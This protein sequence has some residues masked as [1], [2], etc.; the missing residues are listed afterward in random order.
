MGKIRRHYVFSGYVQGVGFRYA[1]SHTAQHLGV[2]GWVRN[3]YDGTVEMEAEGT[4]AD[5]NELIA[6][7]HDWNYG[8]ITDIE[9]EEI[10]LEHDLFFDIR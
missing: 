6:A 7:L 9:S 10:P 3:Q 5:L 4:P 1:A 8:S 2:T